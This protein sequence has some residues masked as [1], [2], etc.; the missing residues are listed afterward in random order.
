[1]TERKIESARKLPVNGVPSDVANLS[2]SVPTIVSL[3]SGLYA[4][5]RFRP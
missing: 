3:D 4:V 1:M 5:S 2:V